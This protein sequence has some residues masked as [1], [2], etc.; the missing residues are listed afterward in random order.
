MKLLDLRTFELKSDVHEMLDSVWSSLVQVDL[1]ASRVAIFD[2]RDGRC[3]VF[4]TGR[5][6]LMDV[7]EQMTLSDTVTGLKAYKELEERMIQLWHNVDVAIVSPRMNYGSESL[8]KVQIS[9]VSVGSDNS[10][11]VLTKPRLC[12]N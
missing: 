11:F 12:S 3:A 5:S 6:G 9:D 4:I 2:K 1:E 7:G 10:V 8:P